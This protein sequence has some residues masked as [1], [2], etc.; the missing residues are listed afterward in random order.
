MKPLNWYPG[1]MAKARRDIGKAMGKTEVIFEILDARLPFSSENPLVNSLR[2]DTPCIKVLNKKDLADP[3]VTQLWLTQLN[4]IPGVHAVALDSRDKRKARELLPM[5]RTLLRTDRNKDKPIQTM[6]LGVPNVGKST[7]INTLAG[8]AIAKA[9][10]KPAVTKR[11]QIVRCPGNIH[12]ID[13]PGF[14]WPKLD[15]PECGYRL[16]ISGAIADNVLEYEHLGEFAARYFLERYPD[17]LRERFK[18]ETLPEGAIAL[19]EAIAP[20]RGCLRKGGVIDLQKVS[21]VLVRE[22]R[23]ASMGPMSLEEPKDMPTSWSNDDGVE[24]A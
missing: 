1:H 12:L 10:N 13:T 16:A 15:P 23:N 19:L 18:L 24:S 7:L 11:Q 3:R 8:R 22:F 14:L 4:R 5:A 2:R 17:R 20:K 9:S 21:E 6:I